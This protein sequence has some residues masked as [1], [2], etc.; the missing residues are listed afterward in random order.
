MSTQK[1]AAMAWF[2]RQLVGVNEAGN[3]SIITRM[4]KAVD[5]VA[6]GEPWCVCF[7]QFC[8]G[9]VD[10]LFRA[11]N[12]AGKP[13]RLVATESTQKLFNDAMPQT[14]S[15]LPQPGNIVVWRLLA[16]PTRG[17][18]GIVIEATADNVVTVEGNTSATAGST[19]AE[20]NGRGVWCKRRALGD[21]PGFVRLGYL[22]PWA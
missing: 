18:C 22:N 2:A 14:R 8:A 17:H 1:Q 20:R 6:A 16:D 9:E 13:A 5:G 19:E 11:L 4:R 21:I 10:D 3:A 12:I 15:P 7:T